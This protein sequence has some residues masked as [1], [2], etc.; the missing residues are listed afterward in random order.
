LAECK[1]SLGDVD[2]ALDDFE[3]ALEYTLQEKQSEEEENH[4]NPLRAAL[5]L[6]IGQSI[7]LSSI[8]H[9]YYKFTN[10]IYSLSG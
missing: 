5:Y 6:S 7:H 1:V 8:Y 4:G 9:Q 10:I 2:G 3:Q